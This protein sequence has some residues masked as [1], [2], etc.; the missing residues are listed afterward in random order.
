[1]PIEQTGKESTN[2]PGDVGNL[3]PE[4]PIELVE[5]E[6]K[7]A[8]SNSQSELVELD[9]NLGDETPIQIPVTDNAE[10]SLSSEAIS[11][12]SKPE[13]E[14]LDKNSVKDTI[15]E[16]P[17]PIAPDPKPAEEPP[18]QTLEA[19]THTHVVPISP[20]PEPIDA[21]SRPENPS[22]L[23]AS[24][25]DPVPADISISPSPQPISGD[26]RHEEGSFVR[27][28]DKEASPN[29]VPVSPPPEPIGVDTK[30]EE[31]KLHPADASGRDTKSTDESFVE[32]PETVE[33]KSL[34]ATPP[35]HESRETDSRSLDEEEIASHSPSGSPASVSGDSLL[36]EDQKGEADEESSVSIVN[37]TPLPDGRPDSN[38]SLSDSAL[39]DLLAEIAE[40]S[41]LSPG[42][43][44][45]TVVAADSDSEAVAHLLE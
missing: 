4:S 42:K 22:A 12:D 43:R 16:F 38:S 44:E 2:F 1:V 13:E 10:I 23:Q 7:R 40:T 29:D 45:N 18:D 3:E 31:A 19:E 14:A 6:N 15:P 35:L 30:T 28:S 32:T 36:S 20:S 33:V 5:P 41:E 21:D 25:K 17:V 39:G 24:E 34:D 27:P 8:P 11:G 37:S 9:L 26:S